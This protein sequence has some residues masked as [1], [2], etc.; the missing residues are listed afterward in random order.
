MGDLR[1]QKRKKKNGFRDLQSKILEGFYS[2][3]LLA[4]YYITFKAIENVV[5]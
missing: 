2:T 3:I 5:S 1:L 4:G